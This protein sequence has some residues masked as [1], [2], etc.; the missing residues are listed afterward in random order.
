MLESQLQPSV[1]NSLFGL[2]SKIIFTILAILGKQ[3]NFLEIQFINLY[4]I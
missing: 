3:L 1:S 2:G 4:R